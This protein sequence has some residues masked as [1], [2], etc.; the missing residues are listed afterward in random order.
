MAEVFPFLFRATSLLDHAAGTV[1]ASAELGWRD[2]TTSRGREPGAGGD[3]GSALNFVSLSA[4][5]T[6][7]Y[8][9]FKKQRKHLLI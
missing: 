3:A 7:L 2:F 1:S 9:H 4:F 6:R 8:Q 5:P